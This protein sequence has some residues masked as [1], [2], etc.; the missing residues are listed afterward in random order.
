[1]PPPVVP[2]KIGRSKPVTPECSAPGC[3]KF[4]HVS[5]FHSDIAAVAMWAVNE[6]ANCKSAVDLHNGTSKAAMATTTAT[7]E[8]IAATTGSA[9]TSDLSLVGGTGVSNGSASNLSGIG[10]DAA[11]ASPLQ[12]DKEPS[13]KISMTLASSSEVYHALQTESYGVLL[14]EQIMLGWGAVI[15]DGNTFCPV[16]RE[17]FPPSLKFR[18]WRSCGYFVDSFCQYLSPMLLRGELETLINRLTSSN[19]GFGVISLDDVLAASQSLYWNLLWYSKRLNLPTV[20]LP[21]SRHG[22]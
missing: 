18:I 13:P 20:T 3:L 4:G 5:E 11:S 1:M 22:E 6:C 16:C 19:S 12:P 15:D 9:G 10:V 17:R 14:D 8:S 2:S 7:S 21:L